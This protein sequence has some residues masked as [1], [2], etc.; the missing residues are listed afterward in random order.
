MQKRLSVFTLIMAFIMTTGSAAVAAAAAQESWITDTKTGFQVGW[1]SGSN[2]TLIAASWSGSAVKGKAEGK[3]TLTV[4]VRDKDG[5]DFQG[6]GEVEMVAGLLDGKCFLKWTGGW[7]YDGY[8]K[9]GKREGKGVEKLPDG[10]IYDG[11]WKNGVPFGQ[12]ISITDGRHYQGE[13]KGRRNGQGIMK[14][15]NGQIYDG[16]WKDDIMDGK[17]V[18]KYN[19]GTG[20][21]TYEGDFRNDSPNGYGILKDASGNVKYE[22]EW[23]DGRRAEK[24]E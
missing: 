24:A 3:G 12:G 4:T 5:K 17:G 19:D 21:V 18:L 16:E 2:S 15:P 10:S 13:W 20:W 6:G 7:I 22:G 14:W 23:K 8:Y 11:E 1:V 9:A